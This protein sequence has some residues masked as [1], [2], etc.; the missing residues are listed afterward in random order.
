[1]YEMLIDL[2]LDDHS[3]AGCPVTDEDIQ[4]IT[5]FNTK[6]ALRRALFA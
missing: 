6:D 5:I 3:M 2:T 1:M 4:R